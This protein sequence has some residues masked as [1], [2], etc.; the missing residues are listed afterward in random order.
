MI[1]DLCVFVYVQEMEKYLSKAVTD[2]MIFARIDRLSGIIRFKEKE[3]ANSMLNDWR[4]NIEELLELVDNT[5]HQIDKEQ[6]IHGKGK[7]GKPLTFEEE[8]KQAFAVFDVN[9][10]G[11]I[12]AEEL[13][14]VM[15]A[16]GENLTTEDVDFMIKAIDIV[17]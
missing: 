5:T 3:T 7:K 13:S 1:V 14:S 9:G 6:V 4:S 15:K 8:L 11:S 16:L 12:T 17:K 10:D 2:K